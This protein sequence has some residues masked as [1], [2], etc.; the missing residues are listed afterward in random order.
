MK[1]DKN[2]NKLWDKTFGGKGT[3][4]ANSIIQT[5]DSNFIVVGYTDSKGA[6][7]KDGWIIKIDKNGNKLWDKTFGSKYYDQFNEVIQSK[8][9]GIV[10]IGLRDGES[11]NGWILKFDKNGNKLWDINLDMGGDDQL[12]SII[13]TKNNEFVVAGN[14]NAKNSG[15]YQDAWIIKLDE[16]GHRIWNKV[17]Y[18]RRDDYIY[19][20]I[21]TKDKGFIAVGHTN[22][23]GAG[24]TDGYILKIDKNGNKLWD[25]TFGGSNIDS[26]KS[27]IQLKDKGIILAGSTY[28]KGA[29]AFDMWIISNYLTNLKKF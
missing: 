3:E 28:S 10:V 11:Y 6:G 1:I 8:N 16:N 15:Y 23:K 2:G 18:G 19:S 26:I 25:K 12:C 14:T 9:G 29:G 4:E 7:H 17:F 27:I 13:Q 24:R 22:S 5:K 21:Q 20:L